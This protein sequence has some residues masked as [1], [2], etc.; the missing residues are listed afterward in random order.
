LADEDSKTARF[1][2]IGIH[3][4]NFIGVIPEKDEYEPSVYQ[5]PPIKTLKIKFPYILQESDEQKKQGEV[6]R[7]EVMLDQERYRNDHWMP[8]KITRQK[9]DNLF[10]YS[11]EILDKT[12]LLRAE[13]AIEKEIVEMF[14]DCVVGGEYEKALILATRLKKVKSLSICEHLCSTHNAG[15]LLDRISD[16]LEMRKRLEQIEEAQQQSGRNASKGSE[17]V[18]IKGSEQNKILENR[19]KVKKGLSA[20]A[21]QRVI[22]LLRDLSNNNKKGD[23][24][25]HN[26]MN[27]LESPEQDRN[28]DVIDFLEDAAEEHDRQVNVMSSTKETVGDFLILF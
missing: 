23:N 12:G 26:M 11:E 4:Y 28:G 22:C 14:Q 19:Q 9:T 15:T 8:Y 5:R 21:V 16:M 18:I 13:L 20:Y 25:R 10:G 6:V 27:A 1:W 17:I 3:D 7:K 2:L 24:T